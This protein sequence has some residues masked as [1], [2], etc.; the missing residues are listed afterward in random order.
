[1]YCRN[2]GK[3][4]HPQA[5]ACPGC[6]VSPRLEKKFCLSPPQET[7]RYQDEFGPCEFGKDPGRKVYERESRQ[8]L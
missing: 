7:P 3:E 6:G 4:V 1:M 8:P 2:C 5:V